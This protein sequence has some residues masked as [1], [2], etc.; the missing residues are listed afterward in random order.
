MDFSLINKNVLNYL[1][2][3]KTSML[4]NPLSINVTIKKLNL[5]I[6]SFHNEMMELLEAENIYL[7]VIIDQHIPKP[8]V[9]P[10]DL[11][12]MADADK[13]KS[14][15]LSLS[16]Q[17]TSEA[18]NS[19]KKLR[20]FMWTLSDVEQYRHNVNYIIRKEVNFSY[21]GT[22]F[23]K[24]LVGIYYHL[25]EWNQ[26]KSI[27]ALER[28][29]EGIRN[30]K[31][32]EELRG[33]AGYHL[34]TITD[35]II[36]QYQSYF[37]KCLSEYE[38]LYNGGG[39]NEP[40]EK[41]S[42][43]NSSTELNPDAEAQDVRFLLEN[44]INDEPIQLEERFA[45]KDKDMDS[46]LVVYSDGEKIEIDLQLISEQFQAELLNILYKKTTFNEACEKEQT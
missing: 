5:Y 24:I 12:K 15:L 17:L 29:Y 45:Q 10:V 13:I 4:T 36:Q 44:I 40:F 35:G 9:E 31:V 43:P 1:E 23:H 32:I 3:Q 37:L 8:S 22:E 2:K 18:S 25:R 27:V 14:K 30:S 34:P 16:N 19:S 21:E 6:G 28:N 20:S 26:D 38:R 7:G 11:E 41:A 39:E 42:E 46:L 33:R